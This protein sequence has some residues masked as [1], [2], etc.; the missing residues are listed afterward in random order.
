M[1]WFKDVFPTANA[2]ENMIEILLDVFI[3]LDPNLEFCLHAGIKQQSDQLN[4]LL[5]VKEALNDILV[6]LDGVIFA[7]DSGKLWIKTAKFMSLP[8]LLAAGR[9]LRKIYNAS[10]FSSYLLVQKALQH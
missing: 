4:Y 8:L 1:I 3:N 7:T 5:L 10:F 6:H 2:P 9:S